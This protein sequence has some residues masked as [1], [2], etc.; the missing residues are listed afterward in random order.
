MADECPTPGPTPTAGTA[1]TG[2]TIPSPESRNFL[3]RLARADCPEEP[4]KL[5]TL[6]SAA[7]LVVAFIRVAWAA[8]GQIAAGKGVDGGTQAALL[9]LAVFISALAG[10]V[11]KTP[12]AGGA[13]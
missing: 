10:Y 4:K 2:P 5:V 11:H 1:T 13:Q 7:A 12:D 8:A 9:G 3:V 6:G